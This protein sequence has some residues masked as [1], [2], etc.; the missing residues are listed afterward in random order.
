MKLHLRRP[1][2]AMV[3]ACI[4]LFVALSGA[5]TAA[6][7]TLK[8]NSVLSKHIKNGQVKTS[9]LAANAV[10]SAKVSDGSLLAHDFAAG[11]L[12]A[13][14]PGPQGEPATKLWARVS[15]TGTK[16]AGSPSV[17][18]TRFRTGVYQ[19]TFDRNVFVNCAVVV[20]PQS[21]LSINTALVD[22]PD[23]QRF[24]TL[25]QGR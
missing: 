8:K 23:V 6:V 3:V 22:P 18:S 19:L 10:N 1:S 20:H 9:D 15:S 12:P 14:P 4:S 13:G 21:P 24:F 25:V 7:V 5:G 11:Q 2:P 17:S 16:F